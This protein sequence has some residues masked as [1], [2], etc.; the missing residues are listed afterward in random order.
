MRDVREN[1]QEQGVVAVWVAILAPVLLIVAAFAVDISV[2]YVE[3]QRL[4]KTV[5][6]AALAGAPFMPEDLAVAGNPATAAAEDHITRNGYDPNDAII[7]EG[8]RTSQIR[9][10]LSSTVDNGLATIIGIPTTTLSRTA[11]A[12]FTGPAP[13]GNPCNTLGNEP[14]GSTAPQG[15]GPRPSQTSSFLN[16]SS[17]PEFWATIV[18]PHVYKTQ[19]DRF[20]TRVCSAGRNAGSASFESGCSGSYAGGGAN[21]LNSEFDPRGYAYTIRVL[22]GAEG[23]PITVQLYDPAY[24]DTASRCNLIPGT[25]TSASN[26]YT[27][28]AGDR[29]DNIPN[30]F[31]TG[32][33][34]NAG[35][36]VA[37]N[38]RTRNDGA[39]Q[40]VPTTTSFAIV[41]RPTGAGVGPVDTFDPFDPTNVPVFNQLNSQP[42]TAQIRGFTTPTTAE[43]NQDSSLTQLFHQWYELCQFTPTAPGDYYLRVRTNVPFAGT[44]GQDIVTGGTTMLTQLGDASCTLPSNEPACSGNGSNRFAVRAVPAVGNESDRDLVSISAFER[45]PIFA[46]SDNAST[47]FNLV[48]VVPGAAGQRIIFSFFDVGDATSAGATLRI[49]KPT[50][51]F[52]SSEPGEGTADAPRCIAT[53][54]LGGSTGTEL[55]NCQISGIRNTAGWNGQFQQIVVPIPADYTCG[56]DSAGDTDLDLAEQGNC[57]FRLSVDFSGTQVTDQTT[58]TAVVDG[59]PVR[60]VE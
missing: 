55:T 30:E 52:D 49:L 36:S 16:C 35:Q 39:S 28:D 38:G 34:N 27:N 26:P 13:L 60:L 45:L 18:G 15:V 42:C 2:W 53:G 3:L 19:G 44:S 40:Q 21:T 11:V 58:W 22:P 32:D 10:T 37:Q 33:N 41:G 31:C 57:W 43:L 12:D 24:V 14:L 17:N 46:N 5:D 25:A 29:Y 48:R 47:I 51:A 9:V 56:Q 4:Q 6:A 7:E 59:D 54:F 1:S 50:D 20:A 23:K 8:D